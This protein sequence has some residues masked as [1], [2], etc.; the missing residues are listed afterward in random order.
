VYTSLVVTSILK[1]KLNFIYLGSEKLFVVFDTF[2]IYIN[3]KVKGLKFLQ[4]RPFM[5]SDYFGHI[6]SV[7]NILGKVCET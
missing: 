7:E 6:C 2:T 5:N 4:D 3:N 1:G